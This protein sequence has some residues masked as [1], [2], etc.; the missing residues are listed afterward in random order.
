[1]KYDAVMAK[2]SDA[3]ERLL[4]VAFDLIWDNSY[5]AVSVDHICERANVNKGSFYY[6]F[7]SKADLAV[8]SYE[9]H[10]REKQPE[11]DHIFSPQVSPLERLTRWSRYLIERQ[12][13]KAEKY[14]H[15]CGCP[16]ASVGSEVATQDEKIRAKTQELF[17]RNLKYLDSALVDAKRAGLVNCRDPHV[18]ARRIYSVALG[19]LLR[20]K[21]R[22]DLSLLEDLEPAI[23][24]LVGAEAV[25]G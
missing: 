13:Q 8:A 7:K 17:E 15:V 9:E 18:A 3:K 23:M 2:V 10:W 20:A 6:Y 16:Y 19:M 21:I 22:N 12:K 4:Q 1:M 25:L 11:L 5:S 14:G 24:D